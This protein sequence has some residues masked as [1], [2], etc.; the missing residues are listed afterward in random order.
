[1]IFLC[2]S[3]RVDSSDVRVVIAYPCFLHLFIFEFCAGALARWM[4]W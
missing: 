4:V 3:E 1:M 2:K